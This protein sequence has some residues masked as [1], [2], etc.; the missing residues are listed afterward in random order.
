MILIVGGVGQGKL[1]YALKQTGLSMD[2][3]AFCPVDAGPERPILAHLERWVRATE[4]V[5]GPVEDLLERC[6]EVVILCDQVGCGVVP[7]AREE[8]DWRERVGR[9]C[10]ALAARADRVERL[11]CGLPQVLK[12]EKE[13]WN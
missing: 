9:L 13:K 8:R 5:E 1:A 3:V 7:M 11:F 2:Q 6:P 4:A 10:C 12:G